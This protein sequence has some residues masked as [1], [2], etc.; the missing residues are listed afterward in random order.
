MPELKIDSVKSRTT[1]KKVR[2]KKNSFVL[3]G[4][5]FIT[6][7][8]MTCGDKSKNEH[9][10]ERQDNNIKMSYTRLIDER[11]FLKE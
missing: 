3:K 7:R 10:P 1:K 4:I 5:I 11:Y 6:A 8:S 9:L 2:I